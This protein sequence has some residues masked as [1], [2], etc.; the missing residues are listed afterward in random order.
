MQTSLLTWR[1][2]SAWVS[3]PDSEFI[4]IKA[5]RS[6]VEEETWHF[7]ESS[8]EKVGCEWWGI[9]PTL[10]LWVR[11]LFSV[12][13][14]SSCGR[15]YFHRCH[16]QNAITPL[17]TPTTNTDQSPFKTQTCSVPCVPFH[18][19]AYHLGPLL[20]GIWMDIHHTMI[21]ALTSVL[22][23]HSGDP[24]IG[25]SRPNSRPLGR[26]HVFISH[27]CINLFSSS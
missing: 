13:L 1:S 5:K 7:A 14:L 8:F 11:P 18:T 26:F 10:T 6:G 15:H 20:C 19:I 2:I 23:C 12:Y 22:N 3:V 17:A 24:L 27:L 25:C 21:Y 4:C 16:A 9:G